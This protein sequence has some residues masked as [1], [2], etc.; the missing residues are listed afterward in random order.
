MIGMELERIWKKK[1]YLLLLGVVVLLQIFVLW[2]YSVYKPNGIP[3]SSYK[4][5]DGVMINM[6]EEEKGE[7][8]SKEKELMDAMRFVQKIEM[9]LSSDS[10]MARNYVEKALEGKEEYYE[11]NLDIYLSD[12][13]LQ[14]TDC[15]ED[16]AELIDRVSKDYEQV[17]GYASYIEDT[18]AKSGTLNQISIF[19]QNGQDSFSE[20][21]IEKSAD[22]HAGME[23]I[24]LEFRVTEGIQRTLEFSAADIF[25]V[26]LTIYFSMLLIWEE[27]ETGLYAI[28]R[29]AERGRGYHIVSKLIALMIHVMIT[30][31]VLYTV[32]YL[33]YGTHAGFI[34]L[35][36]PIQSVAAYIESDLR[37]NLFEMMAGIFISK[38]GAALLIGL[39]VMI[40]AEIS[41]MVWVPWLSAIIF[42]LMGIGSFELVELHSRFEIIKF[43]SFF[44]LMHGDKLYGNYI[45]MNLFGLPITGRVFCFVFNVTLL[46]VLVVISIVVFLFFYRG[47]LAE[48][49]R[50]AYQIRCF[51]N[52]LFMQEAY[53]I[54]FM[55]KACLIILFFVVSSWFLQHNTLYRLSA[56]EIYYQDI[57]MKLEGD[58]DEDKQ[59]LIENEQKRYDDAFGEIAKIEELAENGEISAEQENRMKSKY[60]M[61]VSFYPQ[62]EKVLM[63]Y[64][65]AEKQNI[66]FLYDTGYSW[67]F[68]MNGSKTKLIQEFLLAAIAL[69][70]AIGGVMSCEKEYHSWMLLG[71]TY[72]GRKKIVQKKLMICSMIAFLMGTC[73]WAFRLFCINS[74]YPIRQMFYSTKAVLG[75]EGVGVPLVFCMVAELVIHIL[76]YMLLMAVVLFISSKRD[77]TSEVYVFSAIGIVI[78]LLIVL[79]L[80]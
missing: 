15:L 35:S 16:E 70:L 50:K 59:K 28:T 54:F 27:K 38:T 69:I 52:S 64:E 7:Y 2:Y 37:W 53:K 5:I 34:D 42:I 29:T 57:M 44:C 51:G 61:V 75:Y 12:E 24:S 1:S 46:A 33:W 66:P 60:E 72:L 76:L 26:L 80:K 40:T 78:P 22:D 23:D 55:N 74:K 14:F 13:Y 10:D 20:R 18:V 4:K 63:H 32:N 71:T 25:L 77:K 19:A 31:A 21:N 17:N 9:Y 30:A 45:N 6:T 68:W 62:F 56:K 47:N 65:K 58:L 43:A 41:R 73:G 8:L 11:E 67:L 49:R 39:L 3:L 36:M 79:V 48:H